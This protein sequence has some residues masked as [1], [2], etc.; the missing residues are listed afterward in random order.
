MNK[1]LENLAIE[2]LSLLQALCATYETYNTVLTRMPYNSVTPVYQTAGIIVPDYFGDNCIGQA[3]AVINNLPRSLA[4]KSFYLVDE[5]HHLVITLIGEDYY[6]LD[7]Y[8][9]H[10]EPINISLQLR[11]GALQQT[12]PAYPLEFNDRKEEM[13]SFISVNFLPDAHDTCTRF[14]LRKGRFSPSHDRYEIAVFNFDLQ[15][16]IKERTAPDDPAIAFHAEQTTLSIRYFDPKTAKVTHLIYPIA[17]VLRRPIDLRYL[18][19]K[20]A[21]GARISYLHERFSIEADALAAKLKCQGVYELL[22]FIIGGARIYQQRASKET[23]FKSLNP[24]NN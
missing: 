20:D 12:Y 1:S 13:R 18:Y 14:S 4:E 24:V 9:M 6:L 17:T 8:L 23:V 11:N 3:E 10:K 2:E 21:K 7:P 15:N 19:I 22:D 16:R 5:R